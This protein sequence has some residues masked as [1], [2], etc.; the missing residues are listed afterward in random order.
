MKV[1]EE[2]FGTPDMKA[3][4]F[5]ASQLWN[6]A[7]D[8]PRLQSHGR[9]VGMNWEGDDTDLSLQL[10]LARLQGVA[11]CDFIPAK[12]TESYI[13]ALEKEGMKTDRYELWETKP[14][15]RD[16]ANKILA[17][18][19]LQDD[20]EVEIVGSETPL[21]SLKAV[22]ALTE[23]C[24]V[25][26]PMGSFVRG[27]SRPS[28]YMYARDENGIPVGHASATA[29]F[30]SN[31]KYGSYVHWGMLATDP[32]RRGEKIALIL[33]AMS[34]LSMNRQHGY[35][36]FMTGIRDGN[37]PSE[38]LCSKLHLTRSDTTVVV[39]IDPESFSGTQMTK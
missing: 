26:L 1:S 6:V 19:G 18:N 33:G 8:N 16:N 31:S 10:S 11:G 20:L 24:G 9:A 34:M 14:D 29:A 15:V 23:K 21:N 27:I 13:L 38:K 25:T 32:D 22:A 12:D 30:H 2:F 17:E 3:V 5:K 36:K 28:V 39:A 4:T 37:V 35:E 7:G